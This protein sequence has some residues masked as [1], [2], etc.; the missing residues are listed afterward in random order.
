M[1]KALFYKE[2]LKTRNIFFV[3]LL[4]AVAMAG[5]VVL[6][7]N[8]L[9]EIH[10]VDHLWLIMLMKDNSFVDF[11]KYV[12]LAVG[13][14]IGAAQMVPEMVQKRLKLTL[15]LPYPQ[16]RLVALML[17]AGIAE[18]L[19][20]YIIQLAIVV[21]YDASI[22]PH[23]LVGRVALT[24]LPW[25]FAGFTAYLFVTAICLEGTWIMRI[26]LALLAVATL[27]IYFL[28]PA[29]EAYN[30]MI[31][32]MIVFILLLTVLSFGSVLRFKEGRQD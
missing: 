4:V 3:A 18:L 16:G 19:V 1:E 21:I 17:F 23:E 9:I 5:Y 22:L 11:L 7:M 30:G 20:I 29:L 26:V 2:W 28:Q 32:I 24:M 27:M 25:Y 13:L 6:V 10:G 14:A 8:R 31:L 12:P 15:H